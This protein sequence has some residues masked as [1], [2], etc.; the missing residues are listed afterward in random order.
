[1]LQGTA[2]TNAEMRAWGGHALR[3]GAFDVFD[4]RRIAVATLGRGTHQ[5]A[6]TGQAERHEERRAIGQGGDSIAFLT[7]AD[8][9][10]DVRA[11]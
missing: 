3:R 4:M 9:L 11:R 10:D 5:S 8:D 7:H 6:L 1:M 2:A